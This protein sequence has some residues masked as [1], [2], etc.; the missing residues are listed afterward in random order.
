VVEFPPRSPDLTLLAF[1]LWG[2][3]R[4]VVYRRKMAKLAVLWEEIEMA[5][6]AIHVDTFVKQ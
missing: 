3:L 4:D 5:C 1:Y 2:T 6:A